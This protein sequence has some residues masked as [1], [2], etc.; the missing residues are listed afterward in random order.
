M[1][2]A[3][4]DKDPAIE[5]ENAQLAS[6]N[7]QCKKRTYHVHTLEDFSLSFEALKSQA[8]LQVRL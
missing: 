8:Y 5:L 4:R 2:K 7:C 6:C 3:L 1:L